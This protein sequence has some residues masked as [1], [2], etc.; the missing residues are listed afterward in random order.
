[1]SNAGDYRFG[2]FA[3]DPEERSLR[4]DG[5]SVPLTPKAGDTLRVLLEQAGR[6]VTK[7]QLLA[8]VWPD[9]FVDEST[10]AQNIS[11]LRKALD[12]EGDSVYIETVPKR[13]YRFIAP[14]ERGSPL[15]TPAPSRVRSRIPVAIILAIVALAGAA[16]WWRGSL[17][18]AANGP[19]TLAILP[20]RNL[21]PAPEWDF[22]GFSLADAVI[23]RLSVV[24]QIIVRPS[25]YVSKYRD[26]TADPEQVAREL[27]VDTVLAGSYVK[28]GND[29]RVKAELVD[30][31]H[32]VVLWRESFDLA[33]G[34]L[35]ILQDRVADKILEGLRV[36]L[37]RDDAAR[38]RQNAPSNPVAYEYYLRG[39]DL[40]ERHAW[41]P[42]IPLLAES[43]ALEELTA[44]AWSELGE[45]Y[46]GYGSFQSGGALYVEKGIAAF[47]RALEI[48]PDMLHA[49]VGL[50]MY[51]SESGQI[52]EA[53]QQL[54]QTLQINP[55]YAL[56]HWWTSQVYRYAGR[57][58]ASLEAAARARE[59]DPYV[60]RGFTQNT[61]L[62]A[63]RYD[64]FLQSLPD[65]NSARMTFY[66]GLGLL[67]KGNRAA[68]IQELDRAFEMDSTLLHARIGRAMRLALDGER[69]DG[70]KI[71]GAL[72]LL[73]IPDG[74]MLYKVAQAYAM[75]GD[76]AASIRALERA[77]KQDFFCYPY[78]SRD[79]LLVNVQNEP[80][81]MRVVESARGRSED[82]QTKFGLPELHEAQAG[83]Q[84]LRLLP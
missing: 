74:E 70:S 65:D 73:A 47:R 18:A 76:S 62:Y 56:A 79:Q 80:A 31:V 4:R 16:L 64:D 57:L 17:P 28:D 20:F 71:L 53:M 54:Q 21:Q 39:I 11:T 9:T 81:F 42:A 37:S 60:T 34:R 10:L 2:P 44:P 41:R 82:F 23:G 27:G 38:L 19:R 78:I 29:L 15:A 35:T 75:L 61:Y 33:Y 13:G 30:V 58:E 51:L 43:V 49:R 5:V 12:G 36:Q 84:A 69:A 67:Y 52:D 48:N 63:G 72:D 66:R 32:D 14:V 8:R 7:D 25:S 1:M 68:A 6:I 26:T 50:V 55:N 3:F 40:N 59:L 83:T 24:P 45:A 22:L 77:V 46:Y